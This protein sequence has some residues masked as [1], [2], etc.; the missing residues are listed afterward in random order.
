M[1][2]HEQVADHSSKFAVM[3]SE[4][5]DSLTDLCKETDR[6]RKMLKEKGLKEEKNVVDAEQTA[7]KMQGRY[8]TLAEEFD[9]VRTGDPT[10]R[11]LN[12][13]KNNKTGPQVSFFFT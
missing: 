7:V 8:N 9:R 2:I 1:R 3:V 10:K 11:S 12:K 13:F 4:M 6:T 5:H